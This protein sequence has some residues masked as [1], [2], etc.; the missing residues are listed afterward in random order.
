MKKIINLLT[1]GLILLCT[2]CEEVTIP[3]APN[4]DLATVS[5][6]QYQA[7]GRALT[8]TWDLPADT[9]QITG[10]QVIK[11]MENITE[12][13]GAKSSY[14]L[15]RADTNQ[16]II[17]TIKVIYGNMVSLGQTITVNVPFDNK[18]TKAAFLL[19]ASSIENLP[20]DEE[21][22]AANWFNENYVAKEKGVFISP[23]DLQSA[24]SDMYSVI[25]IHMDRPGLAVGWQ[26]LPDAVSAAENV[27]GLKAY[28]LDG[29]NLFLTKQAT[30]LLVAIE[31]IEEKYAPN[32]YSA[33]APVVGEDHFTMNANIGQGTYDR[34]KNKFFKKLKES[35]PNGWGFKT[36]PLVS[37]GLRGD[38]N[39]MWDCN[40]F[41]FPG[42]PDVIMDF[43]ITLG[44]TV[45]ATWGHV[46]DFCCAGVVEF[47]P[48]E[49]YVGNIMANGL[50]AFQF[51]GA[52]GANQHQ[53]NI[54]TYAKNV[55]DNYMK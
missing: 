38:N 47:N 53:S 11:N 18:N 52:E 5:N 39:C 22:A 46:T 51:Y 3:N 45:L 12:L 10:I 41:G 17:Y 35:D 55:L 44:A 31:R 9:S 49:E 4:T 40:A 20:N 13:E 28:A 15:R 30:Q 23:S 19:T 42:N 33:N 7:V 24:N 34:R 54:E 8:L 1:L 43:Q 29:G 27:A 37:P 16:D 36:F 48:T 50:A 32:I 25:W 2:A 14:Y 21:K 6:V 26:N